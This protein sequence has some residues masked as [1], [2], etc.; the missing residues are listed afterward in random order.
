MSSYSVTNS[1]QR[2]PDAFLGASLNCPSDLWG[3]DALLRPVCP[4][5]LDRLR[6]PTEQVEHQARS[7]RSSCLDLLSRLPED[8]GAGTVD[9]LGR[10]LV[11]LDRAVQ[12][13]E[14]DVVAAG[15]LRAEE[16]EWLSGVQHLYVLHDRDAVVAYLCD[17]RYLL[18]VLMEAPKEI[19]AVFGDGARLALEVVRPR[20]RRFGPADLF[21]LIQTGLDA[22]EALDRRNALWS[23]WMF[24]QE[25]RTHGRL[26]VDV[27]I[28]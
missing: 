22:E 3:H 26:V 1:L 2:Q 19:Q 7:L 4:T 23:T 12:I 9:C 21:L 6:D 18:P 14:R 24:D 13:H 15:P 28:A 25:E 11:H 27:E 17:A 8:D 20:H 10:A 5:P 16:Q